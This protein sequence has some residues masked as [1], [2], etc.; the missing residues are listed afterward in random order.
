MEI[1]PEGGKVIQ[2]QGRVG[3]SPAIDRSAGFN[4]VIA[5]HP[6]YEIAFSRPRDSRA[7]RD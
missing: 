3:A 2:L 4:S 7:T 6:E 1:L 5:D